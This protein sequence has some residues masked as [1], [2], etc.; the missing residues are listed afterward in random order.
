MNYFIAEEISR[1]LPVALRITKCTLQEMVGAI[2]NCLHKNCRFPKINGAIFAIVTELLDERLKY[3]KEI[4]CTYFEVHSSSA[5]TSNPGY[6]DIFKE[7]LSSI[8][9]IDLGYLPMPLVSSNSNSDNL[10]LLSDA[11]KCPISGPTKLTQ[12]QLELCKHLRNLAVNAFKIVRWQAQDY[13]A[14]AILSSLIY[15]TVDTV[16]TVLVI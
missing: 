7:S 1:I 9:T 16:S 6:A 3:T 5:W 15:K 10:L 12:E 14:K 4:L 11:S 2:D 8:C 13:I